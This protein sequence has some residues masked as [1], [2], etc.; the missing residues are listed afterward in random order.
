MSRK[1]RM[2]LKA[3]AIILVVISVFSHMGI[4]NIGLIP[5]YEYW[6]VVGG[7]GFLLLA[8]R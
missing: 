4:L 1:S 5:R 8:S 7:F 6:M 2:S 3:L